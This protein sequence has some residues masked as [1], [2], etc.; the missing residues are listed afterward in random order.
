MPYLHLKPAV[1]LGA[2]RR[3]MFS[4]TGVSCSCN[5]F[6]IRGF[7]CRHLFDMMFDILE[8]DGRVTAALDYIVDSLKAARWFHTRNT[9]CREGSSLGPFEESHDGP[10]YDDDAGGRSSPCHDDSGNTPAEPEDD[11]DVFEYIIHCIREKQFSCQMPS[12]AAHTEIP[13]ELIR[14]IEHRYVS[15]ED[16]NDT[17]LAEHIIKFCLSVGFASLKLRFRNMQKDAGPLA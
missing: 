4:E 7:V 14:R 17:P 9:Y 15:N 3:V 5:F 8:R 6:W 10:D 13:R 16:L 2:T 11:T 12:A 1:P